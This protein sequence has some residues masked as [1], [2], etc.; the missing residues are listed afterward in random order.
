MKLDGRDPKADWMSQTT[1][2]G[3]ART[4]VCNVVV[5]GAYVVTGTLGLEFDPVAGFA[6][7]V[8]APSGISLAALI[9]LGRWVWPGIAIGAFTVNA[10]QGA[11][12]P[13]A[14][15]MA[16]G[17]TLGAV[18]ASNVLRRVPG[19]RQALDRVADVMG[20]V[21]AAALGSL[22]SA[23]L[24]VP[25]LGLRGVVPLTE[26][27]PTWRVWM[28][29]DLVGDLI[30]A[31]LI[32]VWVAG[33]RI[34]QPLARWIEIAILVV[35]VVAISTLVFS[36]PGS[37]ASGLWRTYMISPPLVWASLRF[38]PR[39][40]ATGTVLVSAVAIAYTSRG[41]GPFAGGSLQE[42]LVFLQIFVAIFAVT[43]LT[44][45]AAVFERLREQKARILAQ[46]AEHAARAADKAKSDFVAV[47]SHELRTPL[48][49]IIGYSELL[50]EGI[51]GPLSDSQREQLERVHVAGAHLTNLIDR[52]LAFSSLESGRERVRFEHVDLSELVRDVVDIAE[53]LVR[54]KGLG[55][56]LE[57]PPA[58]ELDT[59]PAKLRQILLNLISN[60]V[61][62]TESGEVRLI[63]D[64]EDHR[65][66]LS[67]IDTGIGIDPAD[68]QKVFEPFWQADQGLTRRFPGTGLGLNVSRRLA[69][70]MGGELVVKSAPGRGSVF[71]FSGPLSSR[72]A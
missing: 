63:G 17:N 46:K 33:G 26:F 25:I 43:F 40:A 67:V 13:A 37:V 10:W 42:S 32:L 6:T 71:I 38:G 4:V 23:S 39:G 31:P 8:W 58:V 50:R 41:T 34:S 49:A 62:F 5:A 12:I 28:L 51:T 45:G 11:G 52:I 48:T 68:L 56:S 9:L 3:V 64:L 1:R 54:A 18:L 60:A 69:R 29:G 19:F 47:M 15:G 27:F 2:R 44:L 21:I 7:P 55:F 72:A 57:L 61:K 70:S 14:L 65:I 35:A 30:M 16:A 36:A 20:L 59:D 53:P 22:V 66:C 24:G